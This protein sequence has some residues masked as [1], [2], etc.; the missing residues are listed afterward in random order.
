MSPSSTTSTA[1][2]LANS[3]SAYLKSAAHQ[4]IDWYEFS[5]EAFAAAKAQDKPILLDIGAVW[6][7]WCHVID[8]ESYENPEIA[9]LIN[10]G[11]IAIKVDR[12]QRPD[13]DSR[14][15]AVV[16][17]MTGRGG[18]PLT[19]FLAHDGRVIYGG[20]YFPPATMTNLLIRIATVYRE[21]QDAIFK[22]AFAD[23]VEQANASFSSTNNNDCFDE[24][25]SAVVTS[26]VQEALD[27]VDRT[28]GG[29][30]FEPK[31]PHFSTLQLLMARHWH[32]QDHH[33]NDVIVNTLDAM[34][35]GGMYDQ[36]A[37]GFHRYSTD[38]HWHVPHFEKMAYDNAEALMT[39]AAAYRQFG[40]PLYRQVAESIVVWVNTTLSDQVEGGFYASQDADINLEDDGDYFTWTLDE[41][42]AV[43]SVA[44]LN[45]VRHYYGLTAAG[46]MHERPGRNVLQVTQS[47]DDVGRILN[48][49]PHE[50]A[51]LLHAAKAKL[52]AARVMR[53][54]PFVDRTLYT[55][56][57]AMMV[58]AYLDAARLLNLPDAKAFALKTLDLLVARF[59]EP[60]GSSAT[61]GLLAHTDGVDGVLE[62]YAWLIQALLKAWQLTANNRYLE[63][64]QILADETLSSFWDQNQ[65][66]FF[67]IRQVADPLA[68]LA[69]QKKPVEDNPSASANGIMLDNLL[70]LAIITEKPAYQKAIA[71][72]GS[73]FA[74]LAKRY[75]YYASALA[76]ASCRQT[77]GQVKIEIAHHPSV[78]TA[79]PEWL[80]AVQ[81]QY[82]PGLMVTVRSDET[83]LVDAVEA[84]LCMGERCLAPVSDLASI[85][86][87]LV[88]ERSSL[89]P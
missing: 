38:R 46:D 60:A 89:K 66:G 86:P 35:L 76:L 16:S 8:R 82:W 14:Y 87:L 22:T 88:N 34:A 64:A 30:G 12:D 41:A 71:Q 77:V 31:F 4:P 45:V 72:F 29:F 67:D 84:R 58:S 37:G 80:A 27:N 10:D 18:W 52:L 25:V 69:Y 15:Q 47:L 65:G 9:Q 78:I 70:Q 11:F 33:L 59:Y 40:K 42:K 6:C 51:P 23:Q 57:N 54:T 75:G 63:L 56:W 68:L 24:D 3:T 5:P 85:E 13:I 21:N 2:R 83:L 28:H 1:N 61:R 32:T 50:M 36:L 74:K 81:Y 17:Q 55:N 62:D 7:H 53:P 49:P 79:F 43:L 26:V 39:Y 44:E 73:V 19:A 48:V 20:T